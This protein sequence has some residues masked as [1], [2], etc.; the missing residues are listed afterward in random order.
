MSNLPKAVFI[1]EEGPREGFQIEKGNIPTAR[2]IELIEDVE[3][4]G[5]AS[6]ETLGAPG[7]QLEFGVIAR[8]LGL[9]S[10]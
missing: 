5:A 8:P 4:L 2:K 10:E 6:T 7:N 9:D 3:D 1:N